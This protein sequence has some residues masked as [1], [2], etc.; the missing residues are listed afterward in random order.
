MNWIGSMFKKERSTYPFAKDNSNYRTSQNESS[1]IVGVLYSDDEVDKPQFC[2]VADPSNDQ[3]SVFALLGASYKRHTTTSTL[4]RCLSFWERN[5]KSISKRNAIATALTG[6]LVAPAVS[7]AE[8]F[9]IEE[10][11]VTVQKQAQSMNDVGLAISAFSDQQIKDLRITNAVDIALHTPGLVMTETQPAGIPIYTIRGVGFDDVS[12]SSSSTVGVYVDQVALPYPVMTRG[13][14]YDVMRAEVL[15]GPQGDLYGRNNT[16]GAINFVSNIPTEDFKGGITVDAGRYEY[17]RGEGYVSGSLSDSMNG[18]VAFMTTQQGEGWQRSIT[19]DEKLGEKDE[20]AGRVLLG[21]T[22]TEALEVMFNLHTNR[23]RSDNPAPFAIK[24]HN[25]GAPVTVMP[26]VS[27]TNDPSLYIGLNAL[28]TDFG[29]VLPSPTQEFVDV[30]PFLQQKHDPRQSDWS[31]KPQRDNSAWGGSITVD[32]EI[33]DEYWLTS[34]TAY[35]TFDRKESFDY[36]GTALELQDVVNDSEI[37]S[38]SQE[39]RLTYDSEEDLTSIAGLYLSTD[40]VAEEIDGYIANTLGGSGGAFGFNQY[41]QDYEQDTDTMGIFGHAEWQ[42]AEQYRAIFGLRYTREERDWTGCTYD[43]DGG[44]TWLYNNIFGYT[45]PG[46]IPFA[47]GECLTI[48]GTEMSDTDFV[49]DNPGPFTDT[50]S[51]DNVSGKIGLDYMPND[52]WLVYATI[53][54]GFKSGGYNGNP[55]NDHSQL[56]PYKEEEVLA[57]ELGFKASL[58]GY[59]MQ[60]NGAAFFYDYSDKQVYDATETFFGPLVNLTNVPESTIKGA[61]L[62]MLWHPAQGLEVKLATSYLDSEVDKYTDFYG[63]D[64]SGK[65]LPQTPQWQH[66]GLVSYLFPIRAG[67]LMRTSVDFSY[68]DTYKTIISTA[69]GTTN[70]EEME[71]DDW[72]LV[73]ARLGVEPNEGS[74]KLAAWIKNL[75]DKYYQPS[76]NYGND[77]IWA[78]AGEGRTYGMTIGYYWD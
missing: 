37:D 26:S 50:L 7:L 12:V 23:D 38:W 56:E 61:E 9:I 73:N 70:Y 20:F 62:E 43:V 76:M 63:E 53:A 65:S 52:E 66:N 28:L 1:R 10:V 54:T 78:I 69:G 27:E 24:T 2:N 25:F 47:Q 39:L 5:M 71:A 59:T 49:V 19:R 57:Y 11:L 22:P 31:L 29:M 30:T 51:T 72:W 41:Y 32:W 6:V 75:E 8:D 45:K 21:W 34:I 4:I 46:G 35:D 16:G 3:D 55:A 58:L 60:V 67:L 17:I 44:I 77:I 14:I 64:Q 74:W 68:S 42:F 18:R 36:D 15:K 13:V 33:G 48:D 40:T